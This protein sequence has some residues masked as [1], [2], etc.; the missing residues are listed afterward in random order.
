MRKD[1]IGQ[2][3][4]ILLPVM[5]Q[6]IASTAINLVDNVM[7]GQLG[8]TAISAVVTSNR[9]LMMFNFALWGIMG[10]SNIYVAQYYGSGNK[11]A[12]Q[13]SFRIAVITSLIIVFPVMVM[14]ILFPGNI[15]YFFVKDKIVVEEMVKYL[16]VMSI[17]YIPFVL[18]QN[19]SSAMRAVGNIKIPVFATICGVITN[20]TLNY[21]FIFGNFGFPQMGL[22]GAAIATVIARCVEFIIVFS[23]YFR[24]MPFYS[25]IKDFKNIEFFRF[26]MIVRKSIPLTINELAY[27]AG[28]AMLLKIYATRGVTALTAYGI[29]ANSSDLFYSS[30]QGLMTTITILVGHKLGENNLSEAK[31]NAYTIL[32]LSFGIGI[33]FSIVL[34]IVAPVFPAIFNMSSAVTSDAL[35]LA[36]KMLYIV[37][38]ALSAQYTYVAGYMILRIGGDMRSTL[39]LDSG[40]MWCVNI[41]ILFI[42]STTTNLNVLVLMF[43]GHFTDVVKMLIAIYFV[44][45]EKWLVNLSIN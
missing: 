20:T 5:L 31:E 45:K 18:S 43:I 6:S 3:F 12:M 28:L 9:Y 16:T 7:V 44:R 1:F 35:S 10:A 25:K 39:L 19:I 24:K 13:Q 30:F 40:Y 26:K 37:A 21:C 29:A 17:G 23:F 14:T 15:G 8:N 34:A 42:L 22:T 4:K 32:K 11:T 38:F 27:G 41:L 33:L 36:T 2:F